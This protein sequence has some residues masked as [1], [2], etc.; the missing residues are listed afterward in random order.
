MIKVIKKNGN[1]VNF[2]EQKIISAVSKSAERCMVTL[3]GEDYNKICKLVIN[4]LTISGKD[5][6]CVSDL[7]N[8]VL[9]S[10]EL[11]NKEVA[12]CYRSYRNYKVE[13]ASILD[14]VYEKDRSIRFLGDKENSNTDS[15]LVSTKRA[16]AYNEFNRAMYRR[17]HLTDEE[18]QATK[19]G[20]IYNHKN[21]VA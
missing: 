2:D 19:D 16:L 10:L 11:V 8:I 9:D 14:K 3:G 17:F 7:H 20:Y 4:K 6:I 18:I 1:Q 13:F 12:N 15:S 21:I 5:T